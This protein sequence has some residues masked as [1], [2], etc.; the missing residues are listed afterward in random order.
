MS[1]AALGVALVALGCTSKP[2]E[3][4]PSREGPV[5][6]RQPAPPLNVEHTAPSLPGFV[7]P[8]SLAP[9][10][11]AVQ[12]G[13]VHIAASREE[14]A[15]SLGSGFVI[16]PGGLVVTNAH[17]IAGAETIAARLS[18]GR[19]F[20]AR[21]VGRDPQTDL[22][23]L[24]LVRA[25]TLQ[26]VTLGDSDTLEVGDWVVAMGSPFGLDTSVSHGIVS[27]RER[28]IGVGA[29]D[30]FLQ[31]NAPI[32]PGNSGGPLF[33]M[34]GAVIGVTTATVRQGPGV[35]FAVPVNLLR[36]LLP[37]LLDDGRPDR[38][39][40]G[41]N[42]REV[43]EGGDRFVQVT[44]VVPDGPGAKAGLNTGDRLVSIGSRKVERY[45]QM[46]RR[47]ALLGPG[48][49]VVLGVVRGG[50]SSTV[51]ATLAARPAPKE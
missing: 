41:I 40:L 35:A 20:E 43:S 44:D 26:T 31:F 10:V 28:V 13:V 9:L 11:K 48:A 17:V 47:L 7:P 18:D 4:P 33:D 39:W 8:T 3:P 34:K 1:R 32:N 49:L 30:D 19:S 5:E 51:Q 50:Q 21:V 45:Q 29:Y 14:G 2:P 6:V 15:A 37:N 22:A 46:V 25:P 24:W 23:L 36:D 12:A 16:T 42:A 27:A 38:G